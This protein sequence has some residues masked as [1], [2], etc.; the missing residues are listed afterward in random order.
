MSR[1][2]YE[3]HYN[4]NG[5][6]LS[7]LYPHQSGR[8]AYVYDSAGKLD[9]VLAGLSSV[10]Y[11]YQEN[12]N[13]VKNIDI[14]EP[15]FELKHE[16]KYHF[17][18]LKD[19]KLKFGSKS[20]LHNVHMKYQYDGNARVNNIDISIDSKD[21]TPIKMKYNQNLGTLENVNDLRIYKNMF[22]RSVIQDQSKEYFMMTEYDQHARIKSIIINIKSFDIYR[23]ELEYDSRSRI[24]Q[25]K[26]LVGRNSFVDRMSYSADGHILEVTGTNNFKYVYDENGNTVAVLDKGQKLTLGYDIGDRVVEVRYAQISDLSNYLKLFFLLKGK[27]TFFRPLVITL[28]F[29]VP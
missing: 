19:E 11:T 15:N 12:S 16:F 27:S 29:T 4:D 10:H 9:T 25:Q 17:G 18:I 22:N 3:L 28:T 7:K 23:L 24:S 13:L 5:Q 2:P 26:L 6:I 1:H 21:L 14:I 8:V 20:G